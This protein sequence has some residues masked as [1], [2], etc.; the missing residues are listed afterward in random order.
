MRMQSA[1]A[2]YAQNAHAAVNC[3]RQNRI[4][5]HV[6]SYRMNHFGWTMAVCDGCGFNHG[7]GFG[8]LTS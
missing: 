2:Q 7:S 3:A 8:D 4:V 5:H 6:L 1:G